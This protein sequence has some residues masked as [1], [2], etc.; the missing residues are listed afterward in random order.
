MKA[1]DPQASVRGYAP[2][3]REAV[4]RLWIDV[5]GYPEPRNAPER[6]LDDKLA[7]DGRLLVVESLGSVVGT[8]MF[9]YDGHR[10]WLYRL[11]VAAE[12]RR[13]GL[14][15]LLVHEAE[16][17]LRE[18]GC[19]KINLQLHADNESGAAFWGALGYGRE[20]RLSLGKDLTG[21]DEPGGDSGC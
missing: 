11:A 20:V 15:R 1:R 7:W 21:H 6:V 16:R 10:G 13:R 17:R 12:C 19:T 5:F 9:G 8:L 3:D 18:L 14:A 2:A 4:C